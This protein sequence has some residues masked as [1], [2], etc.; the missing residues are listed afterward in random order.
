MFDS[1]QSAGHDLQVGEHDVHFEADS[2]LVLE[3]VG[4]RDERRT[5]GL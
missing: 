1:V 2:D 4:R 3:P 5:M